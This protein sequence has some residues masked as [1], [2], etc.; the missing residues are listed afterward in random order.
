ML[1]GRCL[2]V[3]VTVAMAAHVVPAT[4]GAQDRFLPPGNPAADQYIPSVPDA[5]GE[6][7][8]TP[9]A[10]AASRGGVASG[11]GSSATRPSTAG[12]SKRS[13]KRSSKRTLPSAAA[14]PPSVPESTSDGIGTLLIVLMVLAALG[15]IGF[16]LLR[17]RAA[18]TNASGLAD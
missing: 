8:A 7:V 15:A 17:R 13:S 12:E 9:G 18:R 4:A 1:L 5:S 2:L 11:S 14:V 3:I 6:R 16:V 10:A